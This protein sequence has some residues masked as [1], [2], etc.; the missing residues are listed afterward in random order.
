MKTALTIYVSFSL[1][2]PFINYEHNVE[3]EQEVSIERLCDCGWR[4]YTHWKDR[5]L[6]GGRS[7]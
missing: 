4:D 7:G 3:T 6:G 1:I 2:C 5:P